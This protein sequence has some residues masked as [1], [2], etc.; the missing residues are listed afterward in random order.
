MSELDKY[1]YQQN[2]NNITLLQTTAGPEE[3]TTPNLLIPILRRWLIVLISAVVICATGLPA[4]WLL[5]KPAYAAT[6]AIRVAPIIPSILFGD[7]DSEGIIPMYKNYMNTQADLIKS[8]KVLQRVADELADKNLSF[9]RKTNDAIEALKKTLAGKHTSGIV[10]RLR[11]KPDRNSEL[12]KITMENKNLKEAVQIVNAFVNS[13]MAIAKL[14]ETEGGNQKLAI[15]E[16]ERRTLTEK[17]QRQRQTIRQLAEEYGSTVLT[18]RQEIMLRRVASLQD[19]LTKIQTRKITL[20]ARLQLFQETS[21]PEI[22]LEKMLKMRYD[23]INA[24]PTIQTLSNNITNLEQGLIVAKQTLAPTNPELE[25]KAQLL[26]TIKKRLQEKRQ[27][28]SNSFDEM[29]SLQI[30]K[31]NEDQLANLK[32]ELQQLAKYE[33]KLQQSLEKENSQ[34]IQ[35]GRKHLTI[36]D[37]KEQ[38]ELTRQLYNTVS[39]RI[40]ELEMERKRPARIS[41]AYDA[42]VS[43]LPNK[44]VKYSLALVFASLAAGVFLALLLSKS[45]HSLYTPEDIAKRIGVRIIGTTANADYSD[46]LELPQQIAVDYQ[47]IRANLSM[48]DGGKTPKKLVITSAG[49]REGKTTFSI[50]LATS[51]ANAGKRVLLIDGDLRKPDIR[52]LLNLPKNSSGIEDVLSGRS[53][54]DTI[55]ST[56]AGGFDVITASSKNS[57][58]AFELLSRPDMESNL[59]SISAGYD[60]IV[61]DTPPVL[62]FPDALLWAKASDGVIL[63]SFAGS[64]DEQDLKET[65]QRL[66]QINANIL[67]TILNSVNI[68]NSYNRYGY[69]YYAKHKQPSRKN[70]VMLLSQEKQQKTKDQ[71]S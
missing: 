7:R 69:S 35:L 30:E 63:T 2:P 67:G 59:D 22:S 64:T 55:Q 37:H 28:L 33:T 53:F 14:D 1:R 45:D 51:L 32:A 62:A 5:I 56:A 13:Y 48:L 36:Q 52:I 8:D 57:P 29:A 11:D 10:A 25:R 65:L 44:R 31:N 70:K 15:L 47:T 6:A 27:E 60:H 41:V 26:E 21:K 66:E 38:M 20:E 34:T 42:N 24:N 50:N 18:D 46:I 19:E 3:K 40:Q 39:R 54:Q 4:I 23:F 58:R 49:V 61:I 71:K 17:L 16:N 68:R 43:P 12:I 9:F